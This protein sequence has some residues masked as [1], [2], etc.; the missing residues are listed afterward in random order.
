MAGSPEV[1]GL[2]LLRKHPDREPTQVPEQ[3]DHYSWQLREF[4]Q[5]TL[6]ELYELLRLRQEIFVVEQ[7]CYYQDLDGL[8]QKSIHMLVTDG[9]RLIGYQRFFAPGVEAEEAVIGRII[10]AMSARG[11]GFGFEL[12]RRGIDYCRTTYPDAGIRI[13]AQ[14]HLQDF[15]GR[16]GFHPVSEPRDVDG[17][18]HVDM[19]WSD[20]SHQHG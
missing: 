11:Q 20:G 4:S 16:N 5:L 8:D 18:P 10:V 14:A 19:L 17:I 2:H 7:E 1:A 12:V 13:A 15:Y 9:D 3:F 6:D